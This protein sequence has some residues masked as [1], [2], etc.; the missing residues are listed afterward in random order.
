MF[1]W[2]MSVKEGVNNLCCDFLHDLN[3]FAYVIFQT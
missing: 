3:C 1:H 2:V